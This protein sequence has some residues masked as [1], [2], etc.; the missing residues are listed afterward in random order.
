[1]SQFR[2]VSAVALFAMVECHDLFAAGA[3][4]SIP[5][6]IEVNKETL[7]LLD[8]DV[9]DLEVEVILV[10]N[11]DGVAVQTAVIVPAQTA[12]DEDAD[13][14]LHG[15]LAVVIGNATAGGYTLIV[16]LTDDL[17]LGASADPEMVA[18]ASNGTSIDKD[19]VSKLQAHVTFR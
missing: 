10:R 17:D 15:V 12:S 9:D 11:S 6:S 19:N 8:I 5:F 3:V 7:A 14:R 1:M 4:V 16:Q 2:A 13:E 18:L